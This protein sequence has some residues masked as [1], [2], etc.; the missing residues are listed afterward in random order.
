MNR[1]ANQR[2]LAAPCVSGSPRCPQPSRPRAG[3]WEWRRTWQRVFTGRSELVLL[4]VVSRS[5]EQRSQLKRNSATRWIPTAWSRT[6]H[7]IRSSDWS[8]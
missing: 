6:Q 3:N 2:A 8:V 5:D 1:A 7:R 4:P